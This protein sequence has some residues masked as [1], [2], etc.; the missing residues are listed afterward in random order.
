[1]KTA[2]ASTFLC[3][4]ALLCLLAGCGTTPTPEAAGPAQLSARL[5]DDQTI[6]VYRPGA[7]EP[8]LTQ[9]AASDF[10]P[11]LHPIRTPDGAASYTQFSPDHH[12]HQTGLYW[13]FTRVNGRDY[14]HHPE[15]DYWR[16]V[17]AEVVEAEGPAVA[18]QTVY[19]LLDEA[20]NPVLTETQRWT[21]QDSA[22][23]EYGRLIMEFF[24]LLSRNPGGFED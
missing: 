13:G 12:T 2:H 24:L 14:F 19:D 17:S 11:Y 7:S 18:W 22:G 9:H 1:M 6:R 10:R 23:T 4:P 20:G 8:V 3:I 16:R 15:G 21:M 5:E